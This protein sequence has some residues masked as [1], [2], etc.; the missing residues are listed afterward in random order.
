MKR[1]KTDVCVIGG[2]AAGMLAA[3]VAAERGNSVTVIEPNRYLGKKLGITGKGRCNITNNCL[4]EDV[5]KNIPENGRFL[6]SALNGFTPEDTMTL[7]ENL[8]VKLKTERGGRVFPESDK[9]GDIV[10]ALRGYMEMYSVQVLRER[11]TEILVSEGKITGVKTDKSEI[12]ADSVILATGG[13]SYP[14][15][16]STGDGYRLASCLGHTVIP[17]C[18]SLV[19]LEAKQA[20]CK[21]M[22]GLSLRNVILT[23]YNS[24]DKRIYSELG[25]MLFTHFGISGPL[26]LSAS[27][28]MR[29]FVNDSYYVTIDL[30]PG[31]D[32]T[33]LDARILRDFEKY[34]NRDFANALSDLLHRTMIPVIIELSGI[35]PDTKVHSITR[36][37]RIRLGELIKSFRVD[38]SSPRPIDEAIIT[39]G[40]INTKEINPST[41]QSKLVDGL[42]FAG[43]ILNLDAYT[44][45]FNLQIAWSTA[46]AAGTHIEI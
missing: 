9:A 12:P 20:F 11:A 2:G 46:Y 39:A 14:G 31:L 7:F 19:P 3:A 41:M 17:P 33:K 45:G 18:P 27:A 40:G 43:E 4:V 1:P 22:Q 15:T 10:A 5:I 13:L 36:E 35:A 21:D 34:K 8:G 16:G 6:Y 32:S 38:I 26:V 42:Y 25:E 44:G 30:K 28:H 24:K 29:D 23:A 37:Q